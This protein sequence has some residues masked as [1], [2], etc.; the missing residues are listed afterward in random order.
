MCAERDG[1]CIHLRF[2][3]SQVTFTGCTIRGA[4]PGRDKR[5]L[6]SPKYPHRPLGSPS[7]IFSGCR[8]F[9]PGYSG[10]VDHLPPPSCAVKNEWSLTCASPVCLCGMDSDT[11]TLKNA[12]QPLTLYKVKN[13]MVPRK[14]GFYF[15]SRYVDTRHYWFVFGVLPICDQKK[16]VHL[17]CP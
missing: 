12:L 14:R 5:L 3:D 10:R 9:A 11:F 17:S 2:Y 4:N 16:P 15:P 13:Q 7:P 8:I 1:C 6:S